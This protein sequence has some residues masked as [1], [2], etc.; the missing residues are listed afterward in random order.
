MRRSFA[1][2]YLVRTAFAFASLSLWPRGPA[3]RPLGRYGRQMSPI[4][5][6]L[7]F[8]GGGNVS[9]NAHSQEKNQILQSNSMSLAN[10][11]LTA[12][13]I[14]NEIIKSSVVRHVCAAFDGVSLMPGQNLNFRPE[15]ILQMLETEFAISLSSKK[16]F[17]METIDSTIRNGVYDFKKK[18]FS[19]NGKAQSKVREENDDPVY[20]FGMSS[21]ISCKQLIIAVWKHVRSAIQ[22]RQEITER[23]IRNLL[24]TEFSCDL[25]ERKQ[26][27]LL[28]IKATLKKN[29]KTIIATHKKVKQGKPI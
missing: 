22:A 21:H 24:E 5:Y 28:A 26:I 4:C 29:S 18:R 15:S 23:S 20:A 19:Y 14:S 25:K 9:G 12:P 8:P 13:I 27:I 16:D 17:I 3:G 10:M 11:E 7:C 2:L 1:T 6:S